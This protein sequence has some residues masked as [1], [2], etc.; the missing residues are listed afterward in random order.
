MNLLIGP[1]LYKVWNCPLIQIS[2]DNSAEHP[3]AIYA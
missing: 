1:T 3:L 2:S